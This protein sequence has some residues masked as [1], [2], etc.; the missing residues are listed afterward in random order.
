MN[1]DFQSLWIERYRPKTLKDIVLS[2]EDREFFESLSLKQEIP[3]LLFAGVQGVGKSTIAKVIVNEILDCQYL[4]I[5][6]SDGGGN[7]DSIRG[8]VVGFARTKS[9]DGKMKVVLLDELDSSSFDA[10]RALR[11]MLEDYAETCRFIFTCN[12]LHKIIPALQSRCQ[13][14][15]LNPP[16]DG[17]TQRVVSILKKEKISIPEEQKPLLLNHIKDNLPDIRRIVND[18]QKFSVTGTL[19]I[20]ATS[21]SDFALDILKKI[22]AKKDLMKLRKEIIENERVFANDYHQLQKELFEALF[23]SDV[24]LDRKGDLLLI[25]SRGMEAH[26]L[27][28]DKEINCFSTLLTLSRNIFS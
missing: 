16:I 13:I 4:Y 9:L 8:N 7:I 5:N 11:G 27:V 23:N 2:K 18:I 22:R 14:I 24:E 25:V 6:T 20:R 26:S 12:Y 3:H 21:C 28:I 10:Q 1:T 15:T 19:N 17:V